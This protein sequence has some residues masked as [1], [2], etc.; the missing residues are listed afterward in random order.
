MA[1]PK[2]ELWGESIREVGILCVV[3][4]P[5]DTILKIYRSETGCLD[6]VLAVVI[7]IFG[8]LLMREGGG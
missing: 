5:L 6:L 1:R 3:F 7:A 8:F 2:H 4:A